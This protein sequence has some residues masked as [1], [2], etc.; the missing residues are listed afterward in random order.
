MQN[1]YDKYKQLS[2]ETAS[3]ERL[4]IMLYDGA[5][6]YLNQAKNAINVK[7][8]E[9]TNNFIIKTQD[10]IGELMVTLDMNYEISHRLYSL[11]DYFNRR[12]IEANVK[13]DPGIL[14]EVINHISELRQSW[15]EAAIKAKSQ[16][17]IAGGVNLEG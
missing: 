17:T 9:Q 12:L 16:P 4:I 2:I 14:D 13:K 6:K 15:A 10:I 5:L 7:N 1:G 8:I 3:P 11:Y